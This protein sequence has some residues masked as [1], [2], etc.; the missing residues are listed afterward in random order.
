VAV[1]S[2]YM[3]ETLYIQLGNAGRPGESYNAI[4]APLLSSNVE[5]RHSNAKHS[6]STLVCKGKGGGFVNG[7]RF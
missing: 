2:K 6:H 5:Y 7:L 4:S 1:C 3:L